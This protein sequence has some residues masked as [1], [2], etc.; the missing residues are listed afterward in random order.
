MKKILHVISSPRN[1]ASFSIQLGNAIVEKIKAWLDHIVRSGITF[2]YDANG[3]EG[4]VKG[5]KVYI[6]MASGSVYSEGPMQPYDFVAPYLK[7]ILGFMGMT[8]VKV[9]RV[10]GTAIP[11]I[12][13]TALEKGLKSIVL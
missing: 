1:G 4:L 10:E 9:L 3:P 13:E 5:K 2:R 11:G 8:D 7:W 6:A 12:Q